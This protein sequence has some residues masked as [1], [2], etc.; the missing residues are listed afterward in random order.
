MKARPPR[1]RVWS[2]RLVRVA[3]RMAVP[4]VEMIFVLMAMRVR[5]EKGG[6]DAVSPD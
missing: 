5:D 3:R 2:P 6:P 1:V 4:V